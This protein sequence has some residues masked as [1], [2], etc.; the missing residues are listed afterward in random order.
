MAESE[1]FAKARR[2]LDYTEECLPTFG[3]P[4]AALAELDSAE[5]LLADIERICTE[6]IADIEMYRHDTE[7]PRC[8]GATDVALSDDVNYGK[9]HAWKKVLDRLTGG[10]DDGDTRD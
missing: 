7:I 4:V 10:A 2:I 3:D 5:A 8:K 9:W 1:R 6:G